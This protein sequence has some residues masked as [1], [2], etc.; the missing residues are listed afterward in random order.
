MAHRTG[1]TA[2]AQWQERLARWRQSGLSIS[3]FCRR[4]GVSPPSFYQWRKRLGTG[5]G[6]HRGRTVG[7]P[8]FL[9]V[10]IANAAEGSSRPAINDS[11]E[12]L[13]EITLQRGVM[14][15]IGARV[16]ESRLRG[17]LRA[18]VAETSGC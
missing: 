10:E 5:P 1:G 16:D 17:V 14:V 12:A 2:S 15:R 18:V 4:E 7:R 3:E 13:V 9:P 11:A 6:V 8:V